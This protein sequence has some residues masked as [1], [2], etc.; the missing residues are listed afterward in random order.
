ME[1]WIMDEY[2]SLVSLIVAILA[3]IVSIIT[4]IM[5]YKKQKKDSATL[6]LKVIFGLSKIGA[7]KDYRYE[8]IVINNS[9]KTTYISEVY[10]ELYEFNQYIDRIKYVGQVENFEED[11]SF[12]NVLPF[13]SVRGW[14]GELEEFDKSNIYVR[15]AVYTQESEV[16]KSDIFDPRLCVNIAESKIK[17]LKKKTRNY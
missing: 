6:N 11:N 3:L 9:H 12:R 5:T 16:F 15:I 4:P 8:Y 14:I 17:K 13:T 2:I 1:E 7:G 10:I